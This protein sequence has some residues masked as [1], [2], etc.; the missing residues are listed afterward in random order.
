MSAYDSDA[1][2]WGIIGILLAIILTIFGLLV[3]GI[4]KSENDWEK[5]KSDHKCKK[6]A[7]INARRSIKV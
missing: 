1:K 4:I 6:V 5:F 3:L 2:E 7:H